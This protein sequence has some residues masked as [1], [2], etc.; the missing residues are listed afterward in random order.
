MN[1]PIDINEIRPEGNENWRV[2]RLTR[3]GPVNFTCRIVRDTCSNFHI[4][5]NWDECF[6]VV[7]G[8]V[9]IDLAYSRHC[10]RPGQFLV[11]PSGVVHR[12]RVVG[13]ATILVL[14]QEPS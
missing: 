9:S 3:Q 1:T 14:D 10:L 4:H 7:A 13:E 8:V 11:V 2:L 5:E 12:S 6:F